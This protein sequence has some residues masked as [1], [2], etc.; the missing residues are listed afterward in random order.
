MKHVFYYHFLKYPFRMKQIYKVL[1]LQCL[2][3][4]MAIKL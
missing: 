4:R 3:K 2:C 1:N